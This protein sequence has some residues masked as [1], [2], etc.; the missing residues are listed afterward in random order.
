MAT[1]LK[2]QNYP[3]PYTLHP[4]TRTQKAVNSGLF[5]LCFSLIWVGVAW[6]RVAFG[7]MTTS[8]LEAFTNAE[9]ELAEEAI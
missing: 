8:A 3:H 7:S 1:W 6:V 4:S 5:G 2:L 9:R